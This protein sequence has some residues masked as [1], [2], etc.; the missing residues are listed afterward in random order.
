MTYDKA[1]KN[2]R[3]RRWYKVDTQSKIGC[4][5]IDTHIYSHGIH[6]KSDISVL[7][8]KN[9]HFSKWCCVN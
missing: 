5:E 6:D 7:R 3:V 2:K 4:L 1:K 8:G 9:D